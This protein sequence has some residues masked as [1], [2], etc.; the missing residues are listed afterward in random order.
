MGFLRKTTFVAT[1]GASGLVF[2]ANSK[3]ERAAKA[4]EQQLALQRKAAVAEQRQRVAQENQQAEARRLAQVE[5][6][7]W[8]LE[9][10]AFKGLRPFAKTFYLGGGSF[11]GHALAGKDARTL[12]LAPQG[13]HLRGAIKTL[14]TITWKDVE[15]LD[16]E[17]PTSSER[18]VVRDV[19][20][21][22]K[23]KKPQDQ[24][25]LVVRVSS[26]DALFLI[27]RIAPEDLGQRLSDL[28]RRL[29]AGRERAAKPKLE[30]KSP[31]PAGA[32]ALGVA[33]ELAKLAQLR[34]SGV[35]TKEEFASQKAKLLG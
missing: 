4:A 35:L 20:V 3:K 18:S 30:A 27:R 29:R 28:N 5:S 21:E 32:L 24:T 11:L 34:D 6:G 17:D 23:G 33:D 15:A 22:V 1:G 7:A 16:V 14:F 10:G 31:D 13:L 9:M 12:Q 19:L 25:L 26:G 2:K 8:W